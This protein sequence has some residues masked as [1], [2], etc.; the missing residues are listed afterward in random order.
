[1]GRRRKVSGNILLPYEFSSYPRPARMDFF[2]PSKQNF[3]FEERGGCR[4]AKGGKDGGQDRG[5]GSIGLVKS[6]LGKSTRIDSYGLCNL[7]E[8]LALA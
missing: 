5:E 4:R 8:S 6:E 1:M 3:T 7:R 2:P